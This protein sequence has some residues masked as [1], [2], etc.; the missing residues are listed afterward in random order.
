MNETCKRIL[1]NILYTLPF[2]IVIAVLY[3]AFGITV[4]EKLALA[5]FLVVLT[6]IASFRWMDL[7]DKK[8]KEDIIYGFGLESGIK[9]IPHFIENEP[10][11]NVRCFSEIKWGVTAVIILFL[12]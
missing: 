10:E 2:Y 9:R 8:Y 6:W 7:Y 4:G 11:L 3:L 5:G 12:P 1:K